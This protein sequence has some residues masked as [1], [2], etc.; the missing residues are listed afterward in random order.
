VVQQTGRRGAG[1]VGDEIDLVKA[2]IRPSENTIACPVCSVVSP[3]IIS[4]FQF[5][6]MPRLTG[7]RTGWLNIFRSPRYLYSPLA[8]NSPHTIKILDEYHHILYT[9]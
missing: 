6:R 3:L 2:D 5:Y 1:A 8:R 4:G 7:R 9:F